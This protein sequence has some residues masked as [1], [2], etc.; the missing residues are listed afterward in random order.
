MF[1]GDKALG[2]RTADPD[3]YREI[4][5]EMLR[6]TFEALG[7]EMPRLEPVYTSLMW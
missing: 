5:K 1:A 6:P 7:F 3:E 4:L 2:I